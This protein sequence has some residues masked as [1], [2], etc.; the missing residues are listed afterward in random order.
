[1][2]QQLS[3]RASAAVF[4]PLLPR[5]Y[6]AVA[7]SNGA[8]SH[9]DVLDARGG[10][11]LARASLPRVCA[12]PIANLAVSLC[13]ASRESG[14]LLVATLRD[15]C[16]V[17]WDLET[18]ALLGAAVMPPPA[19]GGRTSAEWIA[20]AGAAAAILSQNPSF[21]N[22]QVKAALTNLALNGAISDVKTGSPNKLLHLEC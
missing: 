4:H 17:V 16:A 3:G 22:A 11:R 14:G 21:T 1:M 7:P 9:V 6:V 12:A 13:C 18:L 10:G 15:G 5:A 20:V 8:P 2:D 19:D